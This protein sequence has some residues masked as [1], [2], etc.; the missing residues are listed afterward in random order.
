MHFICNSHENVRFIIYHPEQ[1]FKTA[2]CFVALIL[3]KGKQN[4]NPDETWI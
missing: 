1:I 3:L 4:K 2:K